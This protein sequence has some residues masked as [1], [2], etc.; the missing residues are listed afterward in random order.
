M[1]TSNFGE[2]IWDAVT[3]NGASWQFPSGGP[4]G[5]WSYDD[6][7]T[8]NGVSSPAI[9]TFTDLGIANSLP[10]NTVIDF[11]GDTEYNYKYYFAIADA[12]ADVPNYAGDDC[13]DT[14]YGVQ[15]ANLENNFPAT[16]NGCNQI[17]ITVNG[18][19]YTLYEMNS[20]AD[21]TEKS[22]ERVS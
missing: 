7:Q 6:G 9:K 11:N 22:Y 15:F 3:L 17:A 10:V 13:G 2:I 4:A 5:T 12:V 16:L 20:T 21:T 14:D 19:P 8:L 18:E 1:P